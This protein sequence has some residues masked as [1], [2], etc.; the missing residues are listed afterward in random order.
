[1]IVNTTGGGGLRRDRFFVNQRSVGTATAFRP[2]T[3]SRC[4]VD[5]AH[6]AEVRVVELF[7]PSADAVPSGPRISLALLCL[8]DVAVHFVDA[9]TVFDAITA[10]N[11]AYHP[12]ETLDGPKAYYLTRLVAE[13]VVSLVYL[14]AD[15]VET[16]DLSRCR[17]RQVRGALPADRGPPEAGEPAR[18]RRVAGGRRAGP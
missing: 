17:L 8:D 1:L 10:A 11:A 6:G 7:A 3:A 15:D 13:T 2:I 9:R 18:Q 4:Y 16:V 5:S 14:T 12:V